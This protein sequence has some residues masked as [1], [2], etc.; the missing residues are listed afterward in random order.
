ME[1]YVM[2]YLGRSLGNH[3]RYPWEKKKENENSK[4]RTPTQVQRSYNEIIGRFGTPANVP[5]IRGKS[6]G[7]AKGVK[8]NPRNDCPIVKKTEISKK[9]ENLAAA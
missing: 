1:S 7:R 9:N 5:K 8:I 3:I 4:V 2:L 6:P